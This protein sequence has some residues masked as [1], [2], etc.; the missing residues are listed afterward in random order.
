MVNT[1]E[2]HAR[3]PGAVDRARDQDFPRTEAFDQS[4]NRGTDT[5]VE[6]ARLDGLRAMPAEGVPEAITAEVPEGPGGDRLSDVEEA[7]M[8]HNARQDQGDVAFKG[9]DQEH[10]EQAVARQESLEHN[11]ST[12]RSRGAEM[13]GANVAA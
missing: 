5:A 7:E 8:G 13:L 4:Y 1:P 11:R 3:I 6:R 12:E 2:Q 9:G 10:S